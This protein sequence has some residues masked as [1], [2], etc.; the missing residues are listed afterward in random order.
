MSFGYNNGSTG[1]TYR[2]EARS[3]SDDG[4]SGGC[5]TVSWAVAVVVTIA[6]VGAVYLL[7]YKWSDMT[8]S[9]ANQ[10]RR[11]GAAKRAPVPRPRAPKVDL[12]DEDDQEPAAGAKGDEMNADRLLPPSWSAAGGNEFVAGC[13]RPCDA[14]SKNAPT[15]ANFLRSRAAE[16]GMV[17]ARIERNG[18][19]RQTGMP[20]LLRTQLRVA[21]SGRAHEFLDTDHRL[22]E[23]AD[24]TGR[25][26]ADEF[27]DSGERVRANVVC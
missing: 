13:K 20:N 2:Y 7:L 26:P 16:H 6:V 10:R 3:S 15:K 19:S 24:L 12:D 9:A 17:R 1:Q 22:R 4:G 5:S 14:W 25:F 8:T 11:L 23:Q 27:C 18:M 21:P